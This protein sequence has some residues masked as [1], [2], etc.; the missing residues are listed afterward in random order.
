MSEICATSEN[1]RA[2]VFALQFILQKGNTRTLQERKKSRLSIKRKRIQAEWIARRHGKIPAAIR[3]GWRM[4]TDIPLNQS[5][6]RDQW[7]KHA[8]VKPGYDASVLVGRRELYKA[9]TVSNF[10]VL[11]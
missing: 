7:I 3:P 1:I 11:D 6:D 4:A 9:Q 10:G 2:D 5:T 8:N